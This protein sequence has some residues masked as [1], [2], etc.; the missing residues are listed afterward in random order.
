[1]TKE[2]S[3]SYKS[4]NNEVPKAQK[5]A[6]K[7][8]K[9]RYLLLLGYMETKLITQKKWSCE[10]TWKRGKKSDYVEK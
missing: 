8:K 1:M 5:M 6:K 4:T 10:I 2:S 9:N 3:G 7:Y